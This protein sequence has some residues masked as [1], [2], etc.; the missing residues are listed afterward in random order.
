MEDK[1]KLLIR[2]GLVIDPANR[3]NGKNDILIED[4][5][6]AKIGKRISARDTDEIEASGKIV[7]PG[8][9]DMH[10]H[11]REP[12]REDKETI[13]TASRAAARGGFTTIVGYPNT[14]PVA[15][16]QTVVSYVTSKAKEEAII[17]VHPV[18][19]IT[20]GGEGD[21][22]TQI[23]D[24]KRAGA[25]AISDDGFPIKNPDVMLKALQYCKMW[26]IPVIAHPESLETDRGGQMHEGWVSTQLG[27]QGIPSVGESI[28]VSRDILLSEYAQHQI[29][30]THI[31][32]G[33]V[34]QMI[35]AAKQRKAMVTCDTCPHYFSLTDEAVTGY[36]R[37]AKVRPPL[38]SKEHVTKIIQGL[39][40]GTIDA[41]STDHAPHTLVEKFYEFDDCEFGMVGL[42]T[43]VPLA[44]TNL[45]HK[46]VL[47]LPSLISKYT[48][49]PAKIL[50]LNKGTLSVGADADITIID[51]KKEETIDPNQFETKGRNSPFSGMNLTGIP[52]MTIANGKIVMAD[53][54]II[55][56]K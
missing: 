38:R 21:E 20:K 40:D 18:G 16:D 44:M 47:D 12:G 22:L 27:L 56:L 51:P 34:V 35:K 29:H 6:I 41:I 36:N 25:V 54:K 7:C 3:I 50:R 10:V 33:A 49:N 30:F 46:K 48:I 43:S 14:T 19:K 5:K 31:S 13:M 4:N 11:L 55:E 52:V 53:R 28:N 39:K 42:E 23:G 37:N 26:D 45:Y 17:N 32:V 24:L 2:N 1:M 9:I 8:L 15:D